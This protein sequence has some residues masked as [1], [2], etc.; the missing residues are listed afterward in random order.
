M[1]S[2][3]SGDSGAVSACTPFAESAGDTAPGR[4]SNAHSIIPLAS[5]LSGIDAARG[6]AMIMVCLSHVR[7]HFSDLPE[8][9]FVLTHL[10]RVATPTFLLLSGFIAVHVLSSHRPGARIAV[11]DRALCVLLVGHF[12]LNVEQIPQV[13]MHEW[14]FA[15]VTITDAIAICLVVGSICAKL[16]AR[17]LGLCGGVLAIVSWPISSLASVDTP[18]ARYVL[19]A[20]F[21]VRSG[22]SNLVDAAIAPYLGLFLIGMA[23]SKGSSGLIEDRDYVRL[24]YKLSRIGTITIVSVLLAALLWH[25]FGGATHLFVGSA[26]IEA[27]IRQTLSPTQKLPPSPAYLAFYGGGG[28]LIAAMCLA[29]RPRALLQPIVHWTATIGR[30]SLM[31][32][33]VQDWLLRSTPVLLGFDKI[34]S[35]VFWSAYCVASILILHWLANRWDAA[36]LN[37]FLTVGL[38]KLN[39]HK[40]SGLASTAH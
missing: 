3:L 16:S 37:R 30:T 19:V 5:R 23:L 8:V 34:E 9:Y 40:R 15:R 7:Y 33:V 14:L 2:P 27:F 11:I 4:V 39:K 29:Q 36:R 20:L 32:F 21:D 24:A 6:I 12:L 18:F 31:C 35:Y 10:T 38:K 13:G 25:E 28:L 17:A 1:N 22:H 26:D